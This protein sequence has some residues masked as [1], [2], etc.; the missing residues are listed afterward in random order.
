MHLLN[1]YERGNAAEFVEHT[2]RVYGQH[3]NE[4][5]QRM[6]SYLVSTRSRWEQNIYLVRWVGKTA[7]QRVTMKKSV[8]NKWMNIGNI[9]K[10]I[11]YDL[12]LFSDFWVLT[13]D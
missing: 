9:L 11:M 5:Y 8:N 7:N 6:L 10:S 13:F 2:M 1:N 3:Q 4:V 12:L